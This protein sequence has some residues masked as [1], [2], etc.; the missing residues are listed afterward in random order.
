[1]VVRKVAF[2]DKQ[3]S[4]FL[5]IGQTI[6]TTDT[7]GEV[8]GYNQARG[9]VFIGKIGRCQSTGEDIFD[10]TFNGDAQLDTAQKKFGT[11]SL[12]LDGTG[13]YLSVASSSEFAFGTG[14][15]TYD[16]WVRPAS[17]ALTGTAHIFDMRTSGSDT[18]GRLY[19][20]SGQ[21]RYAVG[22]TD[23]VTSGLLNLSAN[24]WHHLAVVRSSTGTD[25]TKLYVDGVERGSGID[26]TNYAAKPMDIG[27]AFN[28]GNAFTGHIDEF[29]VSNTNRYTAAF[30]APTGMFQG[31]A[32][33]KMLI[34]FDGA[35]AATYT[36]DWSGA[37]SFSNDE[38]FNNDAIA[39]TWRANS[40]NLPTGFAGKTHRY[41]D[42]ANLIE[43]NKD[44]VAKE[45]VHLLTVQYPSLTI[46]GGNVNCEDDIRD[47]LGALVEDLR[48]GSNNHIWD[49][50]ALYVDRSSTPVTLNHVETEIT[51]TVWAFDKV[52]EM[53][54]YI[55]NNVPWT[56]AGSH[57]VKQRYDATLTDSNNNSLT[58]FDVSA[59]TYNEATGDL[60]LTIGTHSLTTSNTLLFEKL[61]NR[62]TIND[63]LTIEKSSI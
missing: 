8:I 2:D 57:G 50:S 49:A 59:A 42:A 13:D 26:A 29:R 36:E 52:K 43:R 56:V 21:V 32:N 60:V 53:L 61:K 40:A 6:R 44:F 55:F 46:P 3:G 51:E 39:A 47:V 58:A 18:A 38:E 41:Y 33:A 27:A 34:H 30:T 62:S 9:T 31:D 20:E 4:G 10:I 5:A 1:M 22:G 35:Y 24:T 7:K 17:G 19:L 23:I 45:A 37:E 28:A 15:Y 11:A 48:N 25:G 16:I 14:A 63:C 12:L 54:Q